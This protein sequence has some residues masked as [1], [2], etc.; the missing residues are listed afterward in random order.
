MRGN[1]STQGCSCA[2]RATA[3]YNGAGKQCQFPLRKG[4]KSVQVNYVYKTC[5][6]IGYRISQPRRVAVSVA[7]S[8]PFPVLP[9]PC[10]PLPQ[11]GLPKRQCNFLPRSS[12]FILQCH[13]PALIDA[14]PSVSG[15]PKPL[16]HVPYDMFYDS[17]TSSIGAEPHRIGP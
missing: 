1:S 13:S 7:I 2:E 3:A 17:W 11:K 8:V 12:P 10:P 16:V 15:V 5:L 6:V 14:E 9:P 4:N